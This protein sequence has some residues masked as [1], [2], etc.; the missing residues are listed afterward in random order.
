M[1][2]FRSPGSPKT[3]GAAKFSSLFLGS[4]SS[5]RHPQ[6]SCS[7]HVFPPRKGNE[8]KCLQSRTSTLSFNPCVDMSHGDDLLPA[9]TEESALKWQQDPPLPKGQLMAVTK[10]PAKVCKKSA[11]R[12]TVPEQPTNGVIQSGHRLPSLVL[13][14]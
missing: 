6:S 7:H 3:E 12:G 14:C 1:N 10:P 2:T 8:G 4:L 5:V 9:G 11:C 13:P